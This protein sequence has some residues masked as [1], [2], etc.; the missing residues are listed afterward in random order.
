[1]D[2][3]AK[4]LA[5]ARLIE[6]PRFA[7]ARGC[8]VAFEHGHPLP[9]TPRRTFMI[10]EVPEG[11]QRARHTVSCSQFLWMAAGSCT[12]SIRQA[13]EDAGG[14]REF[15]LEQS[16]PGLYLPAGLWLALTAFA[17]GSMLICLAESEYVPCG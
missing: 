8:L 5:E 7:D 17:P 4:G 16:G 11:A 3:A 14:P 9:F 13:A 12:A 15:R 1:M 6:V 2:A 10:S